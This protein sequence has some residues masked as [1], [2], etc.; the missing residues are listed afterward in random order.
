MSDHI[1]QE[2]APGYVNMYLS[3]SHPEHDLSPGQLAATSSSAFCSHSCPLVVWLPPNPVTLSNA[4]PPP[5]SPGLPITFRQTSPPPPQGLQD[6]PPLH[7]LQL[8]TPA[9]TGCLT[10]P[11]SIPNTK[12][13]PASGPLHL[14]FPWLQWSFPDFY[15]LAP[16]LH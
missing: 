12:H 9:Y 13:T 1:L 3:V 11:L 8:F 4:P 15:I 14:F 7:P 2:A 6:E 10:T 16:L 5:H